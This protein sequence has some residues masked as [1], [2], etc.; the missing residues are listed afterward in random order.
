MADVESAV[1][2]ITAETVGIDVLVNNAVF[3]SHRYWKNCRKL[4]GT[5]IST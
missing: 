5:R 1:A 4:T 2:D 3:S